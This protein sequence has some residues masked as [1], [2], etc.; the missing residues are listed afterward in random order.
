MEYIKYTPLFEGVSDNEDSCSSDSCSSISEDSKYGWKKNKL[1]DFC[2]YDILTNDNTINILKD[3]LSINID[4]DLLPTELLT[5]I[6]EFIPKITNKS[7]HDLVDLYLTDSFYKKKIIAIHG[8][9]NN[10]DVSYVTKMNS[11]FKNRTTFNQDIS[12]WDVSK[13]TNM[14]KMFYCCKQL[15]QRGIHQWDESSLIENEDMW[16]KCYYMF[17]E[18]N[19]DS[20]DIDP[21]YDTSDYENDSDTER[22]RER[23]YRSQEQLNN[24]SDEE[25]Y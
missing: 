21:E 6:D 20:D 12:Q 2:Q 16:Y 7:I 4:I 19:R 23:Y 9:I 3:K 18:S 24:E 25:D 11:L 10:W 22:Y 13:V 17:S 8:T 15:N 1:S 14:R 5:I